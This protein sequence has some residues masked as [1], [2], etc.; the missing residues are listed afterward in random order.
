M[1]SIHWFGLVVTDNP[2]RFGRE[3]ENDQGPEK[4]LRSFYNYLCSFNTFAD[5][6]LYTTHEWTFLSNTFLEIMTF[7]STGRKI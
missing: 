3:R 1:W 7:W 4:G 5:P 2:H 6:T